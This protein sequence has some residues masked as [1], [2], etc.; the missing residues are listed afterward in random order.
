MLDFLV[1]ASYYIINYMLIEKGGG[2]ATSL[3]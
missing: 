1:E 3:F 2:N